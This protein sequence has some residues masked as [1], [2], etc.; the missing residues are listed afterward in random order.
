LA[1]DALCDLAISP[2]YLRSNLELR[3]FQQSIRAHSIFLGEW[4]DDILCSS[5]T[6]QHG[7]V[8]RL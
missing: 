4:Y 5:V 1:L 8:I 3:I 7:S 2:T 6:R